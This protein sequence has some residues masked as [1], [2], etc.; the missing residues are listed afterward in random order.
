MMAHL[1]N[2]AMLL[3]ELQ[4]LVSSGHFT[5]IRIS[6]LLLVELVRRILEGMLDSFA[7]SNEMIV[8]NS[9]KFYMERKQLEQR[10]RL[11]LPTISDPVI[12][13]LLQESDLFVRSFHGSSGFGLVSPLEI[14]RV[15]SL[16]TEISSH[17]LLIYSLTRCSTH[18]CVLVFSTFPAMLP[19]LMAWFS[20]APVQADPWAFTPSEA[21]AAERQEKLRNLA[22]S[23]AYRPEV[24]LF[25]LGKWILESWTTSR[26]VVLEADRNSPTHSASLTSSLNLS[27][28]LT[29]L[30]HIPLILMLQSSSVSLGSLTLYRSSIQS[31]VFATRSLLSVVRMAFQSIFLMGAFTAAMQIKPLLEPKREESVPY[32]SIRGGMKLEARGLCFA[33]PGSSEPALRD[34]NFTLEAGE[35]LA[36]VGHNGSGKSTLANVLLRITDFNAGTLRVN[37]VDMRALDPTSF[38]ARVSAVFQGFAKFSTTVQENVGLGRVQDIDA[39]ERVRTAL[40]LADAEGVVRALPAG[41]QTPLEAAAYE[42]IAWAPGGGCVPATG[43][44]GLSGGEWQR[45]AVARAFMRARQPEIDLLLFDEPTSSLDAHAQNHVFNTIADISR[46]ASGARTKSVIFITHRLSTARRAD[47]VAMME[48]GTISE[49]GTHEELLAR[50]GAYAA[51]Y[52]ASV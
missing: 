22:Y 50:N 37:D 5:W 8:L 32:P 18:V 36:I 39:P 2:K 52:H 28:F 21:Q 35:T 14:F 13:D 29:S 4:S 27:E 26:K 3:D 42:K 1:S 16:A 43:H 38:H 17:L 30:Q 44:H 12:R 49:F 23:D 31:V 19:L 41:L 46:D 47:K 48:N 34:V 9:A 7:S 15:L 11:D 51:L 40:R 45:I 24:H 20:S 33:Y 25:G 10:V 6:Q